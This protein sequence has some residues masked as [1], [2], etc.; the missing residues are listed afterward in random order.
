MTTRGT[1]V[2]E[3]EDHGRT[4]DDPVA[5]PAPPPAGGK[6]REAVEARDALASALTLAGMQLPSMDVR[7]PWQDAA[8]GD[9]HDCDA[10]RAAR[11]AL[12]HLGVCS[13]PVAHALAAV[14]AKGAE[15]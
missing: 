3:D 4:T 12:V 2:T 8:A 7:V 13:A 15:R 5:S 11:Y 6:V 14:I 1:A 10:G 9:D